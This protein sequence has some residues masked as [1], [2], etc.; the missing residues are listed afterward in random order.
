L[1]LRNNEKPAK[2][3]MRSFYAVIASIA[4]HTHGPRFTTAGL[5]NNGLRFRSARYRHLI[6]RGKSV[7][8][9]IAAVARELVAFI[10]EMAQ[11]VPMTT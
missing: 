5:A 3:S 8:V 1:R 11:A 10:W 2:G 9:A 6:S 4:V 7:Q